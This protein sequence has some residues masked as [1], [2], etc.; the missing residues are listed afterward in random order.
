MQ[1]FSFP[2]R[3]ESWRVFW[4]QRSV[5]LPLLL[6]AGGVVASWLVS[7]AIPVRP[8]EYRVIRYSIYVGTNWIGGT[9]Q[10]FLPALV[11][12]LFVALNVALAYLTARRTLVVRQLWLWA[13]ALISL[14][15]LWQSLLLA[16]FNS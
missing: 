12:T 11:A 10:S 4:R 5:A 8:G 14:G 1:L 9:A 6:A 3:R 2:W 13:A 16:W 15:F 7:A